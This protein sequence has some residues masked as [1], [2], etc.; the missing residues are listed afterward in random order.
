ME[1]VQSTFQK[2]IQE[3]MQH[4]HLIIACLDGLH[5]GAGT[6]WE[7]G[8]AY[9][10]GIPAVGLKTDEPIAHALEYLSAIIIGSMPM[11]T[12]L[13]DLET[14]LKNHTQKEK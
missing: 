12:S 7:L 13:E 10:K 6:A 3:G 8:Y 11:V 1:E 5:V 4:I 2:D 14:W 9:A